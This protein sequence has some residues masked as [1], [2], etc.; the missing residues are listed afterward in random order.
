MQSSEKLNKTRKFWDNLANHDAQSSVL[1]PNDT[2]GAKTRYIRE[3]TSQAFK[4]A[5]NNSPTPST[6]L[7]F[8][9][10]TGQNFSLLKS[11]GYQVAGVDISFPLLLQAQSKNNKDIIKVQYDGYNL[12]FADNSVQTVISY[13]VLIYLIHSKDLLKCLK[14]INRVLCPSGKLIAIEQ[15]TKKDKLSNDAI[16]LQRSKTQFIQAFLSAGFDFQSANILRRGHFPLIYLIRYG[17]IPDYL[18]PY[19]AKLEKTLG[20]MFPKQFLDYADTM[21]ILK[22]SFYRNKK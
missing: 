3:V 6:L 16:K 20:L 11:L 18:F 2:L 12:P 8:G 9:C 1:D 4:S 15:T 21:F 14:E 19:I 17:L 13:G 7:D 22:K 10:G 5:L